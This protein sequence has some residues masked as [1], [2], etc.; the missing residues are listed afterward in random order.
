MLF[1][2][3]RWYNVC[4]ECC[5]LVWDKNYVVK[6]AC[7]WHSGPKWLHKNQTFVKNTKK[8]LEILNKDFHSLKNCPMIKLI[9]CWLEKLE[10]KWIAMGEGLVYTKWNYFHEKHGLIT[11]IEMNEDNPLWGGYI[12]MTTIL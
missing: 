12:Q 6:G 11:S 7:A 9:P 10:K 8:N 3:E 2:A 1:P 5:Y 4:R